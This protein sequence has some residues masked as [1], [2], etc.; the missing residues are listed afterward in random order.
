MGFRAARPPAIHARWG[1]NPSELD[2][3]DDVWN[4]E[5]DYLAQLA[6]VLTYAFSPDRI[7]YSGGVGARKH[8]APRIAAATNSN[9]ATESKEHV[10]TSFRRAPQ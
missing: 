3:R 2:G 7:L 1:A 8:L 9:S 10:R 6:R 4:L 5:A